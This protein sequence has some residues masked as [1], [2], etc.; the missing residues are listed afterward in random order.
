MKSRL[1]LPV[2]ERLAS[3]LIAGLREYPG[4]F[5]RVEVGGSI[6]RGKPEVRG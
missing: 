1:P 2:A 6:R 3:R 5:S 4:L